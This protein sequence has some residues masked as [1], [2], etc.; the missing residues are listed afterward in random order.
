VEVD[1]Y[2]VCKYAQQ[3]T[4]V[5]TPEVGETQM[6]IR[7]ISSVVAL[8]F[9]LSTSLLAQG[10]ARVIGAVT[11]NG[12]PAE[13]RT[14]RLWHPPSKVEA[15][16]VTDDAGNY[17]IDLPSTGKWMISIRGWYQTHHFVAV[18]GE[19][20]FD[21]AAQGGALEVTLVGARV[22]TTVAIR[23]ASPDFLAMRTVPSEDPTYIFEAIPFG[24]FDVRAWNRFGSSQFVTVT[25]SASELQRQ[26]HLEFPKK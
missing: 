25:F 8:A 3:T 4:I 5:E 7:L 11:L 22:P 19:T 12:Q 17:S 14:I 9:A 10:K 16:T 13:H 23:R 2:F 20:H 21:W 18:E 24:T 15:M 1:H 6:A 26:I